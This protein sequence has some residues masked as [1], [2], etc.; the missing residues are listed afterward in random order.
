MMAHLVTEINI[1]Q[2]GVPQLMQPPWWLPMGESSLVS[3]A[4][5]ALQREPRVP[6]EAPG[7]LRRP[8]EASGGL[9]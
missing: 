1:R 5:L 9:R 7:S 8:Q 6:Q 4:A 2:G 3:K